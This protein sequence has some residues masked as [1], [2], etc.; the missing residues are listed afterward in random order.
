MKAVRYP[1][2]QPF[3]KEHEKVFFGRDND[4][5]RLFLMLQLEKMV[6]LYAKSGI[7]KSS[8]IN[9]GVLPKFDKNPKYQYIQ[10]RFGNYIEGNEMFTVNQVIDRLPVLEKPTFLNDLVPDDNSFWY[11]FKNLQIETDGKKI[12][13]LI[14]DQFEE[15]FSYPPENIFQFKKQLADL[16]YTPIPKN[17]REPLEQHIEELDDNQ[18]ALIE[19]QIP[20]KVLFSLRNDRLSG[21]N[22]LADYLPNIQRTFYSLEPLSREDALKAILEPAIKP[23]SEIIESLNLAEHDICPPFDYTSEAL[24]KILDFLTENNTQP[25]ETTQLQILCQRCENIIIS[26]TQTVSSSIKTKAV[27]A[28]PQIA[29]AD[30]PQMDDIFYDFYEGVINELAPVAQTKARAFIEEELIRKGQRIS[31]DKRLCTD[32]VDEPVLNK[33]TDK[34]LLRCERNTVNS[35]NYELVHDTL[36]SPISKA[37]EKRESVER[38]RKDRIKKRILISSVIILAG[39]LIWGA[40]TWKPSELSERDEVVNTIKFALYSS[41]FKTTI[42]KVLS[43]RENYFIFEDV[44]FFAEADAEIIFGIDISKIRAEDILIQD[45]MLSINL[46]PIEILSFSYPAE[47]F[48]L[49]KKYANNEAILKWNNISIEDRDALYRQGLEDIR[50]N[51][52]NLGIAESFAG[53]YKQIILSRL[54]NSKYKEIYIDFKENKTSK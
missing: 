11:K 46:P 43:A 40:L 12:F 34:H 33:L 2:T 47:G 38:E 26:R 14:F 6:V 36:V 29:V 48:K 10:I 41:N 16:L 39:V 17:I 54:K 13:L 45:K 22:S 8:L 21:L 52:A 35:C 37:K 19:Q 53:Q 7:G 15:L 50:T 44:T 20:V 30:I 24:K 18:N 27:P 1:G 32:F 31:L 49:M 28:N 3:Q 51:I 42:T 5:E 9:A 4:A 25:I 23:A